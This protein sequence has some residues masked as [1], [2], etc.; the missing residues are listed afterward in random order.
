[1]G[2]TRSTIE[3]IDAGVP[4]IAGLGH[5]RVKKVADELGS[6]PKLVGKRAAPHNVPD[7]G[8]ARGRCICRFTTRMLTAEL[9]GHVDETVRKVE[10]AHTRAAAACLLHPC[11]R[12]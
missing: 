9:N 5:L 3:A 10:S 6:H 1:M 12:P 7:A 4:P 11:V 8:I 2:I